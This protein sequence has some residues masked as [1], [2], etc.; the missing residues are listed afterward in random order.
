MLTVSPAIEVVTDGPA[1]SSTAHRRYFNPAEDTKYTTPG[2]SPYPLCKGK[3]EKGADLSRWRQYSL[4]HAVEL[5]AELCTAAAC[6]GDS[7]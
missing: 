5:G 2:T 3:P 4:G 6:F 1:A 7:A